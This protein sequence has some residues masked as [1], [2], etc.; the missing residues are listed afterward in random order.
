MPGR[1]GAMPWRGL[2]AARASAGAA[3][4]VAAREV[5]VV[6]RRLAGQRASDLG[7]RGGRSRQVGGE[8]QRRVG[9]HAGK[10]VAAAASL[11][12]SDKIGRQEGVRAGGGPARPAARPTLQPVNTSVVGCCG[13]AKE[14]F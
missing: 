7:V 2:V 9:G 8:A 10:R 6:P 11:R 12:A 5:G 4:G 13:I 1:V 14:E 3:V